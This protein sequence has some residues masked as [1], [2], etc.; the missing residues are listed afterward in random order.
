MSNIGKWLNSLLLIINKVS[1]ACH[2]TILKKLSANLQKLTSTYDKMCSSINICLIGHFQQLEQIGGRN[3]HISILIQFIGKSVKLQGK[4]L[5]KCPDFTR[6]FPISRTK[7]ITTELCKM[8]NSIPRLLI[9]YPLVE[10]SLVYSHAAKPPHKENIIRFVLFYAS[11]PRWLL[12]DCFQLRIFKEYHTI[13]YF[14]H[15]WRGLTSILPSDRLAEWSKALCSGRSFSGSA[16][17][18]PAAVKIFAHSRQ[19]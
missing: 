1:F 9:L 8:F 2:K 4:F 18:N 5:E 7:G 14:F 15:V 16:G 12:W 10:R 13:L 3:R 17:S 19:S 6:A 11:S